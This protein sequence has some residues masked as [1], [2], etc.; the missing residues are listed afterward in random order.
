MNYTVLDRLL[1]RLEKLHPKFID[2]S[3]ERLLKLLKKLQDPHLKLPN[4]IHIAG[5]N[6][7]GSTLNFI[8]QILIEHNFKVHCYI[9]PH[10]ESIEE[11]FIVANK[12]VTKKKLYNTLKYVEL[13]NNKESITFFEI[14][15]A[16]AFYLFS[17]SKADFLI[18]TIPNFEYS[19]V[20]ILSSIE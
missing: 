15:T 3:L 8:K 6:G 2:L 7:K 9:S 11:R 20:T 10:L 18:S 17:K 12:N 16:A 4:V 5:T 13:V 1:K 14:T 19:I